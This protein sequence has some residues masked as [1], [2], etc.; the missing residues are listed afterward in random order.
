MRQSNLIIS[1]AAIIWAT[2]ILQLVPQLILVPYLISTIGES[3]YGVY[4]L[5]W[6]L[7]TSIDQL[8]RS[9]QSGVVK[10]SAGFLAQGCLD[11]VNSVVSSSF[12]YSVVLAIVSCAGMLVASLF[13]QDPSGQIGTALVVM[14]FMVLFI[15]PLT[16]YIAVIQA[17]QRYYVG[18][19]VGTVSKYVSLLA[20]VIWFHVIGASVTTLI[21]IMALT[22]FIARIAQ[23]PVAHHLVHGLRNRPSLSNKKHFKLIF[24]FGVATVLASLCLALNSTGIR[25]LMDSLSSSTFVAH[26]SIALM[27]SLLLSQIVGAMTITAMPATSA[28]LATGNQKMLHEL[29]IRGMRYSTIMVLAALLLAGFIMETILKIWVG[30]AYV[31][32]APYALILFASGAFMQSTSVSHHMLKGLGKLR[33]VVFIYFIGLVLVPVCLI[34]ASFQIGRNPYT[35]V[36]LGLAAGHLVCG[37]IQLVCCT[38]TIHADLR[39]VFMRVY[40]QPL[41]VAAMTFLVVFGVVNYCGSDGV[42]I[43]F[44]ASGVAVLLFFCGCYAFI[45]TLAEKQQITGMI[46]LASRKVLMR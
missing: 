34:L 33:I 38:K 12:L 37:C 45:A 7:V 16:P 43:R 13:Y 23:V 11:D 41:I 14:G 28:Y 19:I 32:L 35:A 17:R 1:N 18:A 36:T 8:E 29:L 42:Y 2:Q 4:A 31:F 9:L 15:L 20:V 40:A 3:G 24:S 39:D 26:L 30:S 44:I 27:P 6:S 21:L 10:Y 46:Q 22:L 5:I 25:W